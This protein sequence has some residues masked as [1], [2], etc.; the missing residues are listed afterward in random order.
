M[1]CRISIACIWFFRHA[2]CIFRIISWYIPLIWPVD[3]LICNF[4]AARNTAF[5]RVTL[6]LIITWLHFTRDLAQETGR[7][8]FAF[9]T[10][11]SQHKS[12]RQTRYNHK[13]P[14]NL[15]NNNIASHTH[16]TI[17]AVWPVPYACAQHNNRGRGSHGQL[18]LPS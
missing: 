1:G 12:K 5:L 7:F 14:W 8:Y 10:G 2:Y 11:Y 13:Y 6:K 9:N 15:I 16:N 18:F 4:T 17:P 3:L